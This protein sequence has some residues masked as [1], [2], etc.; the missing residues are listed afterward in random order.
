MNAPFSSQSLR[1]Q[2]GKNNGII[3]EIMASQAIKKREDA[4]DEAQRC[5]KGLMDSKN[6]RFEYGAKD[7]GLSPCSYNPS[8][9]VKK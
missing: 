1:F 9:P 6:P 2:E 4:M 8:Y 7:S 5:Y 3:D